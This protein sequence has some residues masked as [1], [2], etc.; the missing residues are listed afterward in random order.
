[1]N[2]EQAIL[3]INNIDWKKFRHT[4]KKDFEQA[5]EYMIRAAKFLKEYS[6][7]PIPPL[8]INIAELLGSKERIVLSDYCSSECIQALS[9]IKFHN[10]PMFILE[11]YL[12]LSKFSD[13]Q[14]QY[15]KYLEVYEPLILLIEMG[16][17]FGVCDNGIEIQ[18]SC[19]Y[20]RTSWLNIFHSIDNIK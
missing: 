16:I 2:F 3:K 12:E 7:P 9:E 1:M 15:K 13:I 20:P 11:C 4:E 14:N 6:L 10:R 18:N 19:W 17:D 5:R 8:Y